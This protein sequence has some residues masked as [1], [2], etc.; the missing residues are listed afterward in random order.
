M[1]L[2]VLTS[3]VAIV[4]AASMTDAAR[5]LGYSQSALSYQMRLLQRD[6]GVP[7][8]ERRERMMTTPAGQEFYVCSLHVLRAVEECLRGIR[9]TRSRTG[10]A[11]PGRRSAAGSVT[12]VQSTSLPGSA[13]R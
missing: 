1:D 8:L 11:L 12:R 5:R 6:V 7:L 9:E 13:A 10:T 2:Q 3:F 4:D